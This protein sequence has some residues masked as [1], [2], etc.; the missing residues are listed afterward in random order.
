MSESQIP[1]EFADS[2]GFLFIQAAK[3]IRRSVEEALNPMELHSYEYGLL[4]VI[5]VT[6]PLPQQVFADRFSIDKTS[7]VD[8]V[9]GLEKRDL[10]YRKR[11]DADRRVKL[12]HLTPRGNA[13]VTRATKRVHK[14][15]KEF[16]EPLSDEEWGVTKKV[17]LKLLMH[18]QI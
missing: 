17:I 1:Q 7:V 11:S 6:G 16:L 5:S 18:H 8:I 13:T 14:A 4:K 2:P 10:I 3:I 9:K 15:H 12:L